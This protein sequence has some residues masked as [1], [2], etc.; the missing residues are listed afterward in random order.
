MITVDTTSSCVMPQDAIVHTQDS[1]PYREILIYT[2]KCYELQ[3]AGN[4]SKIDYDVRFSAKDHKVVVADMLV[5]FEAYPDVG[6][7]QRWLNMLY[8][9]NSEKIHGLESLIKDTNLQ[10]GSQEVRSI[11]IL[12]LSVFDCNII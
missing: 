6:R 4:H 8:D 11:H 10:S 2:K 7:A 12:Y 1:L 5:A 9:T 3:L